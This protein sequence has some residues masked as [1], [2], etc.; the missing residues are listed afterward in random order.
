MKVSPNPASQSPSPL[1]LGPTPFPNLLTIFD[2]QW[3]CGVSRWTV[4]SPNMWAPCLGFMDIQETFSIN[5]S[6]LQNGWIIQH[7]AGGTVMHCIRKAQ[8][9]TSYPV[10]GLFGCQESTFPNQ[11]CLY[12]QA[13]LIFLFLYHWTNLK[14]D[15]NSIGSW[16][17]IR[18]GEDFPGGLGI[19]DLPANAGETASIPD[20]ERSHVLWSD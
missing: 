12:N 3:Q 8:P 2:A 13:F 10:E 5:S 19:K 15:R 20:P 17:Q 14:A 4:A 11:W 6:I 16:C 1:T 7:S 9:K 18:P